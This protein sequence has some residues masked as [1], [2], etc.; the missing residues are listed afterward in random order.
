[1][2]FLLNDNGTVSNKLRC[3]SRAYVQTGEYHIN[4][5]TGELW[6]LPPTAGGPLT[7]DSELVISMLDT[8]IDAHVAHHTFMDLQVRVMHSTDIHVFLLGVFD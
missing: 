1:M 2:S 4:A 5:T 8:V 7:A 6:L 3:M